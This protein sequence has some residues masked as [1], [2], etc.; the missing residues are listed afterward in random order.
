M[1]STAK[2]FSIKK[3]VPKT[4]QGD[5]TERSFKFLSRFLWDMVQ[6]LRYLGLFY[7]ASFN[8]QTARAV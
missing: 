3:I 4:K 2:K 1:K 7:L 8:F 6:M 5:V